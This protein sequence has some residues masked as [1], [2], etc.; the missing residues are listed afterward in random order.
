[1]SQWIKCSERMP[2][3]GQEVIVFDRKNNAVQSG[4]ILGLG[5]PSQ[6]GNVFVDFN[7]EYYKVTNVE[8]WQP[9]PPPPHD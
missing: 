2:E 5:Y 8:W 1:M 7:E 4:M 3:L 9:L 6:M